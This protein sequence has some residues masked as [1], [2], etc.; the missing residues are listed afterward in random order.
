MQLVI[1]EKPSVAQALAAALGVKGRNDGFIQGGEYIISWCV[2]HLVELASADRYDEKYA[3]WR[4]E[5][6]PI[7]P[8][9]WLY[10]VPKDKKKQLK[11]ISDL[12]K[13]SDVD[14]IIC[15]TDAGREGELIFRLVYNHCG[16]KKPVKRL[17]ISSMEESA[18]VDGFRNL[19]NGADYDRLYQSALSRA[20]ADWIVGINAT[21]LFSVLYRQTLNVGRVM[22]PTLALLA[23]REAAIKGFVKEPFYTVE[24][25]CGTFTLS[26][27]RLKDKQAAE[28]IRAICD[29]K[30]ATITKVERQEKTTAAPKLYD[31]TTLQREANRL[32][33][34][35]AQQT[36]DYV[37]SLYEKKLCTYPR[38]DSRYL[39]TDMRES[40]A[41]LIQGIRALP[42]FQGCEDFNPNISTICDNS[43]VTDH[44]AIIPT[45]TMPK[46]NLSTLPTG[47]R[48][49]LNM[50]AVRL[51]CATAERHAYAETTVTADCEGN[52]F[53]AKGKTVLKSGWKGIEQVY[54]AT[55]KEKNKEDNAEDKSLPKISKGQVY[56]HV[57]SSVREGS[58][59][60][61]K[62][63]S[64]DTL[65]K[66]METAG[67]A[68]H[69]EHAGHA[70]HGLDIP[71]EIERKG[72]GTPAT[73]AG[74]I[75]KLVKTGFV[76]RKN[77]QLLP[78]EKGINLITI[79]PEQLKSPLLTAEWESK[80]KEIERGQLKSS[81]FMTGITEMTD[82]LVKTNKTPNAQHAKLF[83]APINDGE[84][85]GKCPR[86]G[87]NVNE[88]KK[89]FFCDN[90]ACSFALWRENR[91]FSIK[92]KELS[93]PIAEALLK[94]GRVSMTGLYSE[95]TGKTYD[96]V[97]V[98][99][100]TG[101]K[102]VNFKMEFGSVK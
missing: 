97:I 72:L 69:I 81:M 51:L 63:Y 41:Q 68:M 91:F 50:L 77:K 47:E 82:G 39:T 24:I 58:T 29:G 59:S 35:T 84:T 37:Q 83:Y 48:N 31:L 66:A 4:Y 2:G 10:N 17:W 56:E 5:D 101:D 64:E 8:T 22:T 38:T 16:C 36:L 12:M 33:G 28:N 49:L 46:G 3:K 14:T 34:Y 86:C 13:R 30:N 98:L 19:R 55:L 52:T 54:K 20:Q 99:D 62:P 92:K 88:G 15:A 90:R 100:D 11:I 9:N 85:V 45:P 44:H 65:L 76:V 70:E 71:E 102:Y 78:S 53:S 42:L 1:S 74:I 73:R 27:E 7:T 18:I 57:K 67:N 95:K 43:K 40:T 79:L 32:F 25:D 75:E 87:G 6:L 26:G 93:R 60:P 23:E 21:R 89:G 61:P 94:D 80:L 96:A